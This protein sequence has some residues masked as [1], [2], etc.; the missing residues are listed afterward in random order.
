MPPFLVTFIASTLGKVLLWVFFALGVILLP[1]TVWQTTQIYGFSLPSLPIIGQIT[2]IQGLESQVANSQAKIDA[3]NKKTQQVSDECS[4]ATQRARIQGQKDV[5][6][7]KAKTDAAQAALVVAQANE[8]KT[9]AQ[10]MRM[11]NNAKPSDTRPLGPIA[12]QYLNSLR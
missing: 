10:L 12:L 3:A 7:Q 2:L 1:V 4:S 9:H 11:L 5:T 8:A 6:D